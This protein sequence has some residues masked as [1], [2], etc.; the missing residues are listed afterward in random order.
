MSSRKPAVLMAAAAIAVMVLAFA[1]VAWTEDG[2]GFSCGGGG[3]A[4][5]VVRTVSPDGATDYVRTVSPDGATDYTTE[6][7]CDIFC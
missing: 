5:A 2:C 1:G 6:T 3:G 7:M 4:P